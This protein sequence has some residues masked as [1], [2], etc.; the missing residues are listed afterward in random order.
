[1]RISVENSSHKTR[2]EIYSKK[3]ETILL[4]VWRR[5]KEKE[6][7]SRPLCGIQCPVRGYGME[8]MHTTGERE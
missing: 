4:G 1:M 3:H 6:A 2:C 7:A 8:W 5:N